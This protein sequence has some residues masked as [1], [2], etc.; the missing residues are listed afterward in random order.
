MPYTLIVEDDPHLTTRWTQYLVARGLHVHSTRSTQAART[1]LNA[2]K[3]PHAVVLNLHLCDGS[4]HEILTLLRAPRF[5]QTRLVVVSTT[6]H[7]RVS[8]SGLRAADYQ[9]LKPVS[10]RGLAALVRSL[11]DQSH[12][13]LRLAATG[14]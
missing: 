1:A 3:P 5:A 9:L 7:S 11:Y 2:N 14:A 6:P 4:A 10:P 8:G 13:E 12:D